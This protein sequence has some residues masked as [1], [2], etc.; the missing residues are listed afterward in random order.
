MVE[1]RDCKGPALQGR[2]RLDFGEFGTG[3]ANFYSSASFPL[4]DKRQY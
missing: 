2:P 4:I 1:S 3:M